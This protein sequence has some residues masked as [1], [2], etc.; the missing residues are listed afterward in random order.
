MEKI[1]VPFQSKCDLLLVKSIANHLLF[2]TQT[3]L[4]KDEFIDVNSRWPDYLS[5][6]KKDKDKLFALVSLEM[7]ERVINYLMDRNEFKFASL[8]C[9]I[10]IEHRLVDRSLYNLFKK[11]YQRYEQFL[12]D[13]KLQYLIPSY[14]HRINFLEGKVEQF[15]LDVYD[16]DLVEARQRRPSLPFQKGYLSGWDGADVLSDAIAEENE[17]DEI[18]LVDLVIADHLTVTSKL[19]S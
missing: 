13:T 16:R 10:C 12:A 5:A 4:A 15:K 9:D 7:H 17:E 3:N 19:A 1:T 14:Q 8:Y 11:V 18:K 2:F 6:C